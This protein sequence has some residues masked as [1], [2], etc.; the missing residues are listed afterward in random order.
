VNNLERI[1]VRLPED[2][3]S[4]VDNSS[5]PDVNCQYIIAVALL[6]GAVSFSNSH[7]RERMVDPQVRAVRNA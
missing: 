5:V 3:A 1:V 6:D 7:S 2:S 4:I